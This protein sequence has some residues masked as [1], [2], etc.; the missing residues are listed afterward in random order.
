M[1]CGGGLHGDE[2][3][4]DEVHPVLKRRHEADLGRAVV[5]EQPVGRDAAVE[6]VHRHVEP[7]L[8]EAAVDAADELLDGSPQLPVLAD[9]A[10][11]RHR[12]LDE[13]DLAAQIRPQLEQELDRAQA[14]RD[15][16]CVVEPVDPE[17]EPAAGELLA[18]AGQR[19]V[20]GRPVRAV[21]EIGRID[22]DRVGGGSHL[23]AVAEAKRRSRPP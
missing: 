10:A 9:L 18:E 22:R 5:R 16:L 12:H 13:G 2:L 4:G 11:A 21:R 14:L 23:A 3:L 7:G 8:G 15:P 6:V 20:D 17:Q 19:P 1:P